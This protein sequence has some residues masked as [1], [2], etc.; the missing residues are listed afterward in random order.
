MTTNEQER[1]LQE[2]NL[3]SMRALGVLLSCLGGIGVFAALNMDTSVVVGS[4]T[5]Q[6]GDFQTYIPESR[7]ENIGLLGQSRNYIVLSSVAIVVGVMLYG[8]GTLAQNQATS[9]QQDATIRRCPEC[10]E[11]IE[12]ELYAW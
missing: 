10:N 1:N 3:R 8:F 2:R 7:V 5:I 11:V 9:T 6:V 12:G 4:K